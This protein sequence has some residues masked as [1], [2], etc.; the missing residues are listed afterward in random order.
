MKIEYRV[1]A[2]A[3]SPLKP[4]LAVIGLLM[5]SIAPSAVFAESDSAFARVEVG[6][7]SQGDLQNWDPQV[8]KNKTDYRLI[9]KPGEMVLVAASRQSASGLVKRQRIDLHKTPILNWR[10][11]IDSGL[12]PADERSKEGDDYAARVYVIVDGG[13]FFWRTLALN[14]VWS[15]SEARGNSWPNAFAGKNAMMQAVRDGNDIA[16]RWY[17]EKRNVRNDFKRL[18]GKDLRY[19][20]AVAI[21]TDTDNAGGRV[22]ATY[23]DIYFSAN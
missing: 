6:R 1:R 8:F 14:Y 22:R 5:A 15:A 20:D 12:K 11:K 21:M 17:Q 3:L 7:F 16:E 2:R 4:L 23:G 13:L 9:G 10:W 19:I 18:H